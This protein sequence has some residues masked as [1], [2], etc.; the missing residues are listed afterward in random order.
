LHNAPDAARGIRATAT[1]IDQRENNRVVAK[2]MPAHQKNSGA[3]TWCDDADESIRRGTISVH[4]KSRAI[5]LFYAPSQANR[6]I[7]LFA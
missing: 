4:F 6:P 5:E 2:R 7:E 1:L 3:S